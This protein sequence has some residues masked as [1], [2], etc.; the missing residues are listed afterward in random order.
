VKK[1]TDH[2]FCL[3]V[4]TGESIL[5]VDDLREQGELA[6]AILTKL[7]YTIETAASGDAALEYLKHHQVD[8]LLLDMIMEPGI[9]GLETSKRSLLLHPNQKTIIASG[10]AET[11]RVKAAIS[12]GVGRQYVN[13]PYTLNAIGKAVREELHRV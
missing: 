2:S 13:K 5:V 1:K 12:L 4:N 9:D 8:L 11:D 10:Y 6:R 7:G 3:T